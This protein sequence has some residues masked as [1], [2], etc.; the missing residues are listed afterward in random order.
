MP[1]K[2]NKN[3]PTENAPGNICLQRRS[4]ILSYFHVI[5]VDTL[6]NTKENMDGISRLGKTRKKNQSGGKTL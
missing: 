1:Q 4:L 3:S 6:R 5:K 2:S